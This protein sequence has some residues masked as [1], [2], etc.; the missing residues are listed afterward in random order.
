MAKITF[1]KK[2]KSNLKKYKSIA[3]FKSAKIIS[4]IEANKITIAIFLKL[5]ATSIVA[6]SFFGRSRSFAIIDMFL[7][8]SS[9]PVSI[10]VLVRE[11]K[12][13]SEPEINAEH[14]SNRISMTIP[15]SKEGCV[16]KSVISKLEGSGSKTKRFN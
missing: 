5:L 9:N 11:N 12:A 2:F 1:R 7:E 15:E 10:S 13:T 14:R 8:L 4:P 3:Q 16:V 6:K